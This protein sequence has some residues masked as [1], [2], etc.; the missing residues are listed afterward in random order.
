MNKLHYRLLASLWLFPFAVTAQAYDFSGKPITIVVPYNPGGGTDTIARRLSNQLA[1]QLNTNVIIEN[2]AGADGII[3]TSAVVR[4]KPDG[5]TY[6]LVVNTHIVNPL[7]HKTMPYDTFK[8]LTGVTMIAKSPLV[9][10]VPKSLGVTTLDELIKLV[11]KA[12]GKYA[13]GSSE[14]FTKRVG[15]RFV[16]ELE[17]DMINVPYSGGAPLM[18][19][20]A[21]G[22]TTLGVGSIL[23][24][25]AY[26]S[27]GKVVPIALTGDKAD[28][29]LPGVKTLKD[30]G[31][32]HFS[33]YVTYSLFAPAKTPKPIVQAMQQEVRKAVFAQSVKQ[34][35]QAQVAEPVAN[36]V[37]QFN[38]ELLSEYA[39]LDQLAKSIGMKAGG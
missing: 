32:N 18:T 36:P 13:Y 6:A 9:L 39:Q 3:G 21:A 27:S 26:I 10:V 16:K 1:K 34:A 38:K 5:H 22:T 8:D 30:Q 23:A 25:H 2:K 14:N 33:M 37:E 20:V 29:S 35:L 24:A 7:F 28:D 17:L 19:D 11:K 31:M 4:A 15:A 12:P